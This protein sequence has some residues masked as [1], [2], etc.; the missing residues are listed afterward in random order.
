MIKKVLVMLFLCVFLLQSVSAIDTEIKLK[1]PSFVEVHLTVLDTSEGFSALSGP[2]KIMAGY[3][4]D[5]N[6][7][8]SGDESIFDLMVI[9][10]D[11][12]QTIYSKKYRE[13]YQA[14]E[15]IYLEIAPSGYELLETPATEG[16]VVDSA[17]LTNSTNSTLDLNETNTT[18]EQESTNTT[19]ISGFSI[20]KE[21]GLFSLKTLLYIIGAVLLLGIALFAF[22]FAQ[23]RKTRKIKVTK[24]S[25]IKP[26]ESIDEDSAPKEESGVNK[27]IK[28]AEDKLKE[29]QEEISGLKKEQRI[30]EIK[31]KM[32]KDKEELKELSRR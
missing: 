16:N 20:F 1:V 32:I 15:N 12:G 21:G 3:Y 9:L 11:D 19:G 18:I 5:V 24:L 10:K 8:Y 17:N 6:F 4:G 31:E 2:H 23:A 25:D 30:K 27:L 13:N 14:G 7:T 22:K 28:E 26:S 29:A